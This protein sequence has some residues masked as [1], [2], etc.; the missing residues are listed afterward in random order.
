MSKEILMVADAVSNEKGVSRSVIF[1]AI[2][3]ALATA[4]KKLYDKEEIGCRVSVDRDTG[5]Y[6][7]FRVWTVV[8]ED[9]Y[10]EEGSQ[11]TLEQ[12]NEKDKSLDIGDTWEEKID[13]VEFGRIAA[14]T[15]KQVI[16][17]KVREAEREIVISEYKD[18][19]GELVAGTVKKVTR[20]NIIVDLGKNAEALLPRDQM[21]PRETFRIGDRMRALLTDVESEQ[22]GPQLFLSRTSPDMLIELF[23]IEVPEIAEEIIEIKAA[24][25]DPGSRAKIVVTTNDGRIDPVG[26]CVGMR[27]SRVQVVS[28]ELA[29]E[30]IDI[31]LWNDN[32]A[33][34]VINS[35][36]PAEVASIIVEEDSHTMDIAVEEE[37][38]AQ[39]IGRNGQN[40]RLSSQLTG[41]TI[42]VMSEEE[43]ADKQQQEASSFKEMF[44]QQLDV[45]DEVGEVLVQE[46]FTSLEEIA[47]VP[48]DEIL[49]IEGFDEEIANELRNRAKDALLTQAIASQED[50]S[51]ANIADDLL[52]MEG[53]DDELAL[54]LAK[55]GILSME[56][57]A[58][59]S[60]DE[61]NDVENMDEDRAGKLIMTARAPWFEE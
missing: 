18:R 50:L 36:A 40:V 3:S 7:T 48:L 24:A 15:A 8:D 5:D 51:S 59:Q 45:E 30:R 34:L 20:D 53:M 57:L 49:V 16:V 17:Q 41:W 38:L 12:A 61:L 35:M 43:A 13:N 55:K 54:A 11:F 23:K 10:E 37:N 22:R 29:N 26:A 14:Q 44:M 21:I 31:I 2:E 6:E 28:N 56:D 9:E 27:G 42:N 60:I 4:T 39:A 25:R 58:E 46:G 19:V 1:E 32:P 47:Y 52:N 33:Q